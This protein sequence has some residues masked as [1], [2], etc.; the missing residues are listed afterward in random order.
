MADFLTAWAITEAHEGGWVND[1]ADPGGNTYCGITQKN[2]PDLR[3]WAVLATK[4]YKYNELF[5]ELDAE[6]QQFYN[7]NFWDKI[8]LNQFSSQKVANFTFDWYVNSGEWAIKKLQVAV[9]VKAD[10]ETGPET[11]AAV[12]RADENELMA[13][14]VNSRI[15]FYKGIVADH[16][17]EMKFLEGWVNRV[18]SFA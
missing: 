14:L 2:Y 1:P 8:L 17:S 4:P 5:P 13:K 10:G 16:P 9:G 18:N 3:I 6:V 7:S 12:N 15:T 11:I